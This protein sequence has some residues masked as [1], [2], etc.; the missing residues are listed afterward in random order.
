MGRKQSKRIYDEL[1]KA[2]EKAESLLPVEAQAITKV[3]KHRWGGME[4]LD[5]VLNGCPDFHFEEVERVIYPALQPF[6]NLLESLE[7]EAH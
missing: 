2:I 7:K 4:E 1:R 5:C 6:Y 3:K